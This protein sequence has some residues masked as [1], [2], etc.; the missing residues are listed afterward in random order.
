M[1]ID[2]DDFETFFRKE[3]AGL[4]RRLVT[5]GYEHGIAEHAVQDAMVQALV[6]WPEL[7][8]PRAWVYRVAS[9]LAYQSW[10]RDR[11]RKEK[12]REEEQS[13]PDRQ[14]ASPEEHLQQRQLEASILEALRALPPMQRNVAV[15]LFDGYS[16]KEVAEK[17]LITEAAVRSHRR[18]I[19]RRLSPPQDGTPEKG[20][21]Q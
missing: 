19:R 20:G 6:A 10:N 13:R 8:A 9:R 2:G 14:V 7:L 5:V 3:Y 21:V 15:L 1:P 12:Q 17:L 16:T 18:H 4:V 11:A